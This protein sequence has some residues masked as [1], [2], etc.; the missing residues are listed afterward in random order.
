MML[1]SVLGSQSA[2]QSH[3]DLQPVKNT[4]DAI[5]RD[6]RKSLDIQEVTD[7]FGSQQLKTR[8][9]EGIVPFADVT[10]SLVKNQDGMTKRRLFVAELN[11]MYLGA[12]YSLTFGKGMGNSGREKVDFPKDVRDYAKSSTFVQGL[13]GFGGSEDEILV[14]SSSDLERYIREL[15]GITRLLRHHLRPGFDQSI[16]YQKNYAAFVKN[17]SK[18]SKP[19]L[20]VIDGLPDYDIPEGTNVY[21]VNQDILSLYLVKEDNEFKILD[22]VV[23]V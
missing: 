8:V 23:G 6:F 4:V 3:R 12:W 2:G 11:Y 17:A 16:N 19:G 20:S 9:D 18:F 15:D 10:L 22:F 1:L 5:I 21:L 7:K 14:R 13:F